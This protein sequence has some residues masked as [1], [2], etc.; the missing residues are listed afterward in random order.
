MEVIL[1]FI[2]KDSLLL[3]QSSCGLGLS[4]ELRIVGGEK[5]GGWFRSSSVWVKRIGAFD[6]FV[7]KGRKGRGFWWSLFPS[8]GL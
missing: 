3:S 7:W 4:R 8:K 5:A 6:F 2:S 1:A